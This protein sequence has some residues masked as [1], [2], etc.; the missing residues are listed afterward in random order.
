MWQNDR[1]AEAP[2][3]L[4]NLKELIRSMEEYESLPS[5]LE[6]VALVMD[7]EQNADTDAVSIMTLHSAKGLEFQTVFLPGWEEGLFPHQRALDE[8]GRSGLEEERRLA[9]V[10]ITRA[11]RRAKIWFV[12][13]RRI[14]GLWQSTI[15]SRFLDELPEAHVEVMEANT[16]YGGYGASGFGGYGASRW[17]GGNAFKE[18]SYKTPGWKRAQAAQAGFAGGTGFAEPRRGG[19]GWSGGRTR[20]ITYDA[21]PGSRGAGGNGFAGRMNDT[22]GRGH[23]QPPKK[24]FGLYSSAKK[25]GPREIQGELV[26]KSVADAESRFAAGDRVFHLKFGNGTVASIDGNKLTVDFDKAGQKRVLEGF[27]EPV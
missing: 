11:K 22:P 6:H 19:D 20:E 17:D 5:F 8:G 23:N 3:R 25:G 24:G 15:P 13:N 16:S 14:H 7:A 27:V 9:Y 10:G 21:E 26:A 12:S 2:G 18:S 4:E 1:S